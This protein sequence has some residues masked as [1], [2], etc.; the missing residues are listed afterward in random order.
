[1]GFVKQ[2]GKWTFMTTMVCLD[3]SRMYKSSRTNVPCPTCAS[4]AVTPMANWNPVR[5]GMPTLKREGI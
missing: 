1:M 4:R 3:C 2:N 5:Y